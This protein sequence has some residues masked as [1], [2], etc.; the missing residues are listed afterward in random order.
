MYDLTGRLVHTLA[1]APFGAGPHTLSTADTGGH[2]LAS[3]LYFVRVEPPGGTM[4]RKLI[5]IQ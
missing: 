4:T 3:G 5:V 2:A 1:D